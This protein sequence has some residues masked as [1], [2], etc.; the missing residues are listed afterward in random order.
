[1]T[2]LRKLRHP[3]TIPRPLKPTLL[4]L[5]QAGLGVTA[6]LRAMSTETRLPDFLIIGAQKCGTTYLYEKLTEHPL[7]VPALTKEVHFF[8]NSYHQGEAW[9]RGHFTGKVGTNLTGEASPY[10]IFHPHA[11]RRIYTTTPHVKLILLLRNPVN[12]AYSHYHHEA[13]L[14]Y[15][16]LSFEDALAQEEK[17][18]AGETEKM[19]KDE[20]YYSHTHQHY[21]YRPKG[22]YADQLKTW[23]DL[24]PQTQILVL[25]SE[26]FYQNTPT[27]M[28]QVTNFLDL[29][30][31]DGWQLNTPK[32]KQ[33]YH[34][35]NSATRQAL[36]TYYQPHNQRL[37]ELIG[38]DFGWEK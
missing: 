32:G 16:P 26:T 36:A 31:W 29:P 13:R 28:R 35:M 25:Q 14:G 21:A 20:R 1:M 34:P 19:L 10:Y 11:A 6:R 8:D 3:L 5:Y 9:Y 18:L 12:R 2:T 17:R 27:V 4:R 30:P 24:F 15:E 37:Y 38:A 22:V 33:R 7:V 23:F